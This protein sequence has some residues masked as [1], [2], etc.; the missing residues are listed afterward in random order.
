[1]TTKKISPKDMEKKIVSDWNENVSTPTTTYLKEIGLRGKAEHIGG[2]QFSPSAEWAQYNKQKS[3]A[4]TDI[5]IGTYN[6]SLKSANDH[7]LMSAKKNEAVATFM[8]VANSLYESEIP[9][10]IND[11]IKEMNS[12]IT[13]GVSPL[14]IAKAKKQGSPVI[15]DAEKKH[16][17]IIQSVETVFNDPVFNSYFIQEVLTGKLKFGA[18][19]DGSAS[20]ILYLTHK[21]ILH[22]LSNMSYISEIARTVDVRIDFKSVQKIQG[23]EI[24][25]YRFWSVLQMISKVLIQ[26]SVLYEESFISKAHSYWVSLISNIKQ[27][28]ST[29]EE[30]FLFLGVSPDITIKLK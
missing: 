25:K 9:N 23:A 20:H 6:I 7:I 26:D 14:S 5:K 3:Y 22:D 1:M 15:V 17:E 2:M 27:S 11:L 28:V 16:R 12:M 19:S 18:D 30:L 21:P 8:C 24:G 29:W 10:V 4:K 13:T